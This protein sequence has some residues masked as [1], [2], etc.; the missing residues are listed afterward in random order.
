MP[1]TELHSYTREQAEEHLRD[2]LRLVDLVEPPEDLRGLAF[3]K[4]VE[5]LSQKQIIHEQV[6]PILGALPGAGH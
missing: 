6:A 5:M 3:A 1:R 2:A 4:A